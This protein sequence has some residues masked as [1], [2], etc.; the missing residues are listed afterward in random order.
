[1]P[2]S[3]HI[4]HCSVCTCIV[5]AGGT[6]QERKPV[7]RRFPLSGLPVECASLYLRLFISLCD[8]GVRSTAIF[9]PRHT[10]WSNLGAVALWSLRRVAAAIFLLQIV[11][12]PG[13]ESLVSSLLGSDRVSSLFVSNFRFASG[14]RK[15]KSVFRRTSRLPLA[16]LCCALLSFMLSMHVFKAVFGES[17]FAFEKK[18]MRNSSFLLF[19][20]T[21]FFPLQVIADSLEAV[22]VYI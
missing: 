5:E 21:F 8:G 7:R 15:I 3:A 10:S 1:M 14:T 6:L 20:G 4:D 11:F 9:P 2:N 18:R 22:S 16:L 19:H 13:R 12:L 17:F